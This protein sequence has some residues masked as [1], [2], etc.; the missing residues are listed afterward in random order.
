MIKLTE[1]IEL[2]LEH[3]GKNSEVQ[4]MIELRKGNKNEPHIPNYHFHAPNNLLNDPNGFCFWQNKWHLF[5]QAYPKESPCYAHWGHAISEDLIHWHDLPIA[6]YPGPETES[7]SG[8][9][10]VENN[11]VIATYHGVGVGNMVAT[12]EDPFLLNWKKLTDNPVVP[13]AKENETPLPYG[14]YDPCIWKKDDYYFCL[15]GGTLQHPKTDNHIRANFL[16]RSKD[17]IHWEYLHQFVEGD[18]FTRVGDDGSCPY[19]F[20]I[21]DQHIL[22]FYSHMSGGQYLLGE[23]DKINDK[24]YSKSHGL[25]NFGPSNPSGLHAPSAI[26]DKKGGIV[27]IFN[28]NPGKKDN[29]KSE[30]INKY[31]GQVMTLPRR[32]SL[33]EKNQLVIKPHGN[34]ESLRFDHKRINSMKL[35]ANEEIILNEVEGNSM[36]LS[37]EINH[38]NSPMIEINVLR[39]PNKE[40]FTRI[41]FFNKRGFKYQSSVKNNIKAVNVMSSALADLVRHESIISIDTSYSSILP[42]ALS[43]APESA[44]VSLGEDELIELRIFVDKSVL[45]VFVNEIQC[46]SVRVYPCLKE[47]I[48]VSLRSQGMDANLISL[49]SWQMK[50]LF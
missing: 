16:L 5:Y 29:E 39:S 50:N 3:M 10:L 24:F 45:E 22:I 48:G 20:P 33:N 32:L 35:P 14:I 30:L 31:L 8:G 4:K 2:Q 34:I 26:P 40:E 7:Y 37:I 13:F 47:S 43:R 17:L 12:S 25:F 23:Y 36:E 21:G 19:F 42:N 44:P 1:E 6:I 41:C 11:R 49:N 18:Y 9:A 27:V 46:V 15:N 38:K 28:M